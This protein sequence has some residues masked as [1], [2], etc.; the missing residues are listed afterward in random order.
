MAVLG[1]E[2]A[3]PQRE[4]LVADH[5]GGK[6]AR[7]PDGAGAPGQGEFAEAFELGEVERQAVR[8][9]ETA[10]DAALQGDGLRLEERQ[11]D[12]LLRACSRALRRLGSDGW[13]R[14]AETRSSRKAFSAAAISAVSQSAWRSCGL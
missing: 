9:A 13:P 7:K 14:A 12:S 8:P 2:Q 1:A 5:L 4:K 6:A 11:F 3:K 10:Q